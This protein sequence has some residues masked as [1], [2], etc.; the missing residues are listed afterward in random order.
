MAAGVLV[1]VVGLK[2]HSRFFANSEAAVYDARDTRGDVAMLM[3]DGARTSIE[4]FMADPGGDAAMA[5]VDEAPAGIA[6]PEGAT[7]FRV[8]AFEKGGRRTHRA[9]Y[10]LDGDPAEI[11]QHYDRAFEARGFERSADPEGATRLTRFYFRHLDH[12]SVSLRRATRDDTMVRIT[13]TVEESAE[14][15]AD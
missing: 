6:P 14:P 15:S 9:T 12:A 5:S 2:L 3:D 1:V 13:V 4:T 10:A 8:D 11:L 7:P